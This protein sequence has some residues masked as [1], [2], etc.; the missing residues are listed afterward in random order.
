MDVPKST[1]PYGSWRS[2]ITADL[3]VSRSIMLMEPR[4]DGADTCWIEGRPAEAGRCVI[5]RR[6]AEGNVA[7]VNP[8]PFNARSRVHEY[9]GGAYVVR[10]GTVYFS[11]FADGVLYRV[12]AGGEPTAI[13]AES[14]Y[15][16][17][18]LVV[19]SRRGR[20]ICVREDHT[21][22]HR[23]AVNTLVSIDLEIGEQTVVVEGNNFYSSPRLSPDGSRLCWLTWNHPNMPWDGCELWSAPIVGEGRPTGAALVAGGLNESIFQPEFSPDGVLFFT[24]DR[25][26][27]WNLYRAGAQG[28]EAVTREEAELGTPQWGFGMSLY[29]FAG[30]DQIVAAV[31]RGGEWRLSTVDPR[32]GRVS[33]LDTP[34]TWAGGVQGQTGRV[35][36][37]AAG[38]TQ[39]TAVVQLDPES[40]ETEVL[41]SSSSLTLDEAYLSRPEPIAFPTENGRTAYGFYHPPANRDFQGPADEKP[42]LIVGVHGGPTGQT[43]N[44]LN[45]QTQYWTSRGFAVLDVNY[46][47]SSGYGREYRERLRE[48]WGVVDVDDAINGARFLLSQGRADP[49]R[50]LIHGGSAGGYT[51]LAALAFRD[52][53]SGGASYFGLADLEPFIQD[54]HKFESR[55]LDGLVGPYPEAKERYRERS[56]IN[57]VHRMSAPVIVF[58]GLEDRVVP[59]NQAEIMVEGLQQKGIPFA[60][61][62]YEGEGHGFRRAE[63]IKHTLE[64]ELYFYSRVFGFD[65]PDEVE[66]VDIENAEGLE[67][68]VL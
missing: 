38:P 49:N 36:C 16:Y 45:L 22:P 35:V 61:V 19:D 68:A 52:F 55:Y 29:A 67:T 39:S 4:L 44:T 56:P 53:F 9:G 42:P 47:G 63:N 23:E 46:G 15:R 17:A 66:T 60:Y 6:D 54:T 21:N 41:K 65:L 26:G 12:R 59:P 8:P 50:V 20:I 51:T 2:P 1:A 37:V 7:D 48:Q 40:G 62:A 11:N 24:S 64:G 58:Q 33:E 28:V 5:V 43:P 25:T 30:A 3:L 34:Y 13:T 27:W 14:A 57:F 32:T 10:D 31:G 18:D